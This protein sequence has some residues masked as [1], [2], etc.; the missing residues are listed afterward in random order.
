MER[1]EDVYCFEDDPNDDDLGSAWR[2]RRAPASGRMPIVIVSPVPLG[3]RIHYFKGSSTPHLKVGCPACKAGHRSRWKGYLLAVSTAD[4]QQIIWEYPANCGL[5]VKGALNEYGGLRG[6]MVIVS[7]LSERVNGEVSCQFKGISPQAHRLPPAEPIWPLIAKI[8]GLLEEV[9]AVFN[10]FSPESLSQ[11]ERIEA[12]LEPV[13]PERV[14]KRKRKP[15]PESLCNSDL[16]RV[17]MNGESH[18]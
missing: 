17:T 13:L 9:P 3:M 1:P 6:Q 5:R 11:A 16:E 10:E 18:E 12:G 15:D 7:R 14:Y 8:M 2:I 4:E